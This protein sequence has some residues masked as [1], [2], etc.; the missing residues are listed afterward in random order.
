[1]TVVRLIDSLT[2]LMPF[3]NGV[4]D[5]WPEYQSMNGIWNDDIGIDSFMGMLSTS[6]LQVGWVYKVQANAYHFH[7]GPATVSSQ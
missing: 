4:G 5:L 2:D 3:A 1:M 6:S 7:N